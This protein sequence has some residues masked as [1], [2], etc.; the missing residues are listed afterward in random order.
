MSNS[1]CGQTTGHPASLSTASAAQPPAEASR[2][3]A[4]WGHGTSAG[5][6][7]AS[8]HSSDEQYTPRT[9]QQTESTLPFAALAANSSS[10]PSSNIVDIDDVNMQRQHAGRQHHKHSSHRSS[11]SQQAQYQDA[12]LGDA[13]TTAKQPRTN[14][15]SIDDIGIG[16]TGGHA[17]RHPSAI[18]RLQQGPS[19]AAAAVGGRSPFRPLHRPVGSEMLDF[20]SGDL[21]L[22]RHLNLD[23]IFLDKQ[24]SVT[25]DVGEAAEKQSHRQPQRPGMSQPLAEQQQQQPGSPEPLASSST[26][27]PSSRPSSSRKYKQGEDQPRQQDRLKQQQEA[28]K[29]VQIKYSAPRP[30]PLYLKPKHVK[31]HFMIPT[32]D[33]WKLHM[34][35]TQVLNTPPSH[36]HP[37]ILCPGLGSS[38]AYSFDLSPAV[39]L[40]DYM[41]GKGWDVWTCELR[42][43]SRFS[44]NLQHVQHCQA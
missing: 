13:A 14:E 22:V 7:A 34:I 12:F 9:L 36:H 21:D 41:A 27:H 4:A 24:E 44:S 37:V 17:S 5:M 30:H 29:P 28:T 2:P 43:I 10:K 35:R 16:N 19:A 32:S 26:R 39:S 31:T 11:S 3:A 33:G 1:R 40:A 18:A 42:G 8:Q 15:V 20:P 25:H 6:H 23:G 38:G